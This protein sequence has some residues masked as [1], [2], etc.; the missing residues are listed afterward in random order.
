MEDEQPTAAQSVSTPSTSG[1]TVRR[2]GRVIKDYKKF[3]PELIGPKNKKKDVIN[4]QKKNAAQ[5]DKKSAIQ[6]KNNEAAGDMFFLKKYDEAQALQTSSATKEMPTT[7]NSMEFSQFREEMTE[8]LNELSERQNTNSEMSHKEN[9][10]LKQKIDETKIEIIDELKV[11]IRENA[12]L[13]QTH[14]IVEGI[15]IRKY[16]YM[17]A[18]HSTTVYSRVKWLAYGYWDYKIHETLYMEKKDGQ[19]VEGINF[20]SHDDCNNIWKTHEYS[21]F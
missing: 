19:S 4:I 6:K 15:A 2:G 17:R 14:E 1:T 11:A 18:E 21:P 12:V 5:L 16:E 20:I 9:D 7:A 13:R 3:S 8:K 10:N